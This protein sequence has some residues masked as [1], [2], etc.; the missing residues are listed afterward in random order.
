MK[1]RGLALACNW[2]VQSIHSSVTRSIYE[3]TPPA[4]HASARPPWIS[5]HACSSATIPPTCPSGSV[6]SEPALSAAGSSRSNSERS[7][8]SLAGSQPGRMAGVPTMIAGR[9]PCRASVSMCGCMASAAAAP[10]SKRM[11]SGNADCAGRYGAR[12][13]TIGAPNRSTIAGCSTIMVTRART[14]AALAAALS[15]TEVREPTATMWTV[16]SGVRS[17]S[18]MQHCSAGASA[19]PARRS[20]HTVCRGT[21]ATCPRA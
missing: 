10:P 13:T 19:S 4:R 16:R 2:P 12:A 18:L 3:S 17:V 5:R 21:A 6:R 7:G 14:A 8:A 15:P 11:R 20:V 1:P 9:T